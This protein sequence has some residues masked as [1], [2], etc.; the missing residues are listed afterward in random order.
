[1]KTTRRTVLKLGAG[2]TFAAAA[3]AILTRRASAA[4]KRIAMIVKN[5]GNSY[6]DACANGAKNAA[7]EIGGI[8]IIYTASAKPTAEDQIAVIDAQSAVGAD[9][10]GEDE[11]SIGKEHGVGRAIYPN[12]RIGSPRNTGKTRKD[13]YVRI[14]RSWPAQHPRLISCFSSVSWTPHSGLGEV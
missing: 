2:A 11:T 13:D 10:I 5:L 14:S 3:P 7:K 8:E 6:F 1:M 4:D 12:R 9:T